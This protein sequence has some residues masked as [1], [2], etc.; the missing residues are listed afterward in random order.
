MDTY[1]KMGWFVVENKVYSLP[2]EVPA[3]G[4]AAAR[5]SDEEMRDYYLNY[6]IRDFNPP[7]KKAP[8]HCINPKTT[9][10]L[11]DREL[12]I[13]R[14][15]G[16]DALNDRE[17]YRHVVETMDDE[18][19]RGM[20][21]LIWAEECILNPFHDVLGADQEIKKETT[22]EDM[23]LLC[24]HGMATNPVYGEEVIR[25][26]G[27]WSELVGH[28]DDEIFEWYKIL[29][30]NPEMATK[31]RRDTM[32]VIA[33][34]IAFGT[35]LFVGTTVTALL[36]Q[37]DVLKW[38]LKAGYEVYRQT[39]IVDAIPALTYGFVAIPGVA[40][41]GLSGWLV[42][43]LIGKKGGEKISEGKIKK[44]EEDKRRV[45]LELEKNEE[46]YEN[47]AES[48]YRMLRFL[49]RNSL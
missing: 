1:K 11:S 38:G 7:G 40:L 17:L 13:S 42:Y 6:L 23:Y 16:A 35:I 12:I 24:L 36:A 39:G 41:G 28:T 3:A 37:T 26:W 18:E 29:T 49:E 9:A 19:L 14:V 33:A 32:E 5:W 22:P 31:L 10:K 8:E 30:I 43:N 34:P 44:I 45:R 47:L 20:L 48:Y 27:E 21:P 15:F 25:R 2:S 46:L 4:L